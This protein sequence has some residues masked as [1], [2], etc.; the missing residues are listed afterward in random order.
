MGVTAT[1]S[2]P[3]SVACRAAPGVN[4]NIAANGAFTL[5]QA[6]QQGI[7]GYDRGNPNLQAEKG[8][9]TTLGVVITPRSFPALSRFT[10]TVDYFNIKIEDAIVATDRPY[11]L[12]QCYGG[13]PSF[14]SFITR[15]PTA[16]GPNSA[17]S[18]EFSDTAVTNSGGRGTQPGRRGSKISAGPRSLSRSTPRSAR[19]RSRITTSSAEPHARAS[20]H[21]DIYPISKGSNR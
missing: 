14:F 17:G 3:R 9:S 13:D 10:F 8:R 19:N 21:T 5:T 16:T 11:T 2:D 6:D 7:S 20:A 18:I 15:R 12:A 1:S 4:A